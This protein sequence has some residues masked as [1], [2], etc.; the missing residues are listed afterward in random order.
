MRKLYALIFLMV[1]IA[2]VPGIS[3]ENGWQWYGEE[4]AVF[5]EVFTIKEKRKEWKVSGKPVFDREADLAPYALIS[6][7][8]GAYLFFIDGQG[9]KGEKPI[10][11]PPGDHSLV[12]MLISGTMVSQDCVEIQANLEPGKE[13][14]VVVASQ[15][16]IFRKG[17]WWPL[18]KYRDISI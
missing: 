4:G 8:G 3:G 15:K 6:G 16:K 5:G 18:L 11:V 9:I 13:Y 17:R 7:K 12:V 14:Q 1:F 10:R 2:G